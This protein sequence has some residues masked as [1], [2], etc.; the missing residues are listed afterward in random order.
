MLLTKRLDDFRRLPKVAL[1]SD[2]LGFRELA[3]SLLDQGFRVYT[4]PFDERYAMQG[5]V[6]RCYGRCSHAVTPVDA[7]NVVVADD[8]CVALSECRTMLIL[9]FH[10]GKKDKYCEITHCPNPVFTERLFEY[11]RVCC[12]RI[13]ED[14]T[15]RMGADSA[16]S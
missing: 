8:Y 16:A 14:L 9:Y 6:T 5:Q 10:H 15:G 2:E 4:S 3:N 11:Y 12:G 1:K 13:H 7:T